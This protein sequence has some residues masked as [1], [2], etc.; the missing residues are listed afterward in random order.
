MYDYLKTPRD[1]TKYTLMRGV[2]DFGNMAQFNMFEGGRPLLIVVSV[3]KMLEKLAELDANFNTLLQN[4]LHILEYEFRGLSGIEAMSADTQEIT[5]NISSVNIITKTNW[6]SASSFSMTY[7]EKSGAVI[8]KVNE[9]FLRGISDP[10][11]FFKHYN[12]LIEK[13]LLDDGYENEVF[14]FL[15]M[16]LDNTGRRLE[17]AVFIVAAQPTGADLT[18]YNAEK[19]DISFKEI[20]YEFNGFPIMSD[21]VNRRAYNLLQDI[22]STSNPNRMYLDSNEFQYS[23]VDKISETDI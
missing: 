13:G 11:T 18:I 16:L 9:T 4:Y 20:S 12:G 7:Q 23:G 21:E 10:R 14:S 19:G 8:T 1:V 6:Q 22:I 3:P 2:T 5:N 15:Y 17:R